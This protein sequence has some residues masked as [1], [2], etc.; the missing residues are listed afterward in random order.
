MNKSLKL[1]A[2]QVECIS[3]KS[4][5]LFSW[6]HQTVLLADGNVTKVRNPP[7]SETGFRIS[8]WTHCGPCEGYKLSIFVCTRCTDTWCSNWLD[9]LIHVCSCLFHWYVWCHIIAASTAVAKCVKLTLKSPRW[10][11]IDCKFVVRSPF[12]SNLFWGRRLCQCL[13]VPVKEV[14]KCNGNCFGFRVSKF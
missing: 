14:R 12:A 7:R 5:K 4:R 2:S 6:Y 8:D 9:W 10:A 11:S 13:R 3:R 1:E